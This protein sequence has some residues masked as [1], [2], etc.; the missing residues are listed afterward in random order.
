MLGLVC[1][2][3]DSKISQTGG[4]DNRN[5]PLTVLEAESP[6]PR[7]RQGGFSWGLSPWLADGRLLAVSANGLS[8]VRA[9]PWCLSVSKFLIRP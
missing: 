9:P 1:L 7:R 5:L 2:D 8:S 6:R 3:C 4:L